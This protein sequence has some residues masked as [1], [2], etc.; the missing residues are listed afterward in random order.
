MS[1]NS[2]KNMLANLVALFF[3]SGFSAL[4]YQVS[5]QRLLFTGF[6]VDL[7]SITV[8]IS[9]FMLGLGIGA[10]FGG[11]IAD[12]FPKKIILLFCCIEL[13]IGIFGFMS[14]SAI[15]WLQE[16]MIHSS[17]FIMIFGVFLLLL[18]PTFLMGS[19]LPL[20]TA[21]FNHHISNIG[22][23]IGQLYFY[24]TLGAA[25]GALSTGFILFNFLTLS[26]TLMLAA[27]FNILISLSIFILY[28]RK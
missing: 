25:M 18:I 5:W 24:N 19:T 13:L 8:I 17:M 27:S 21:F 14:Y 1:R 7:T 16:I 9:I 22:E 28:G 20:L 12:R 10:F 2:L 4:I 26:Q 6:G 3:I 23:S 11:R 15:H